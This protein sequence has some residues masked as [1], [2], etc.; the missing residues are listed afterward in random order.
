M[1]WLPAV[2]SEHTFLFASTRRTA[3]ARSQPPPLT[4]PPPPPLPFT[5]HV[6]PP[7]PHRSHH[8]PHTPPNPRPRTSATMSESKSFSADIAGH[9]TATAMSGKYNEN[10]C[11]AMWEE[12]SDEHDGKVTNFNE[13][14]EV[15]LGYTVELV[16]GGFLSRARALFRS[17]LPLRIHHTP[18]SI[19]LPSPPL[20]P[21]PLSVP[22][23][24][25][26]LSPLPSLPPLW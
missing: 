9:G 10:T 14:V 2:S 16:R 12:L 25:S 23:L 21:S 7:L 24:R 18:P 22:S 1:C 19:S 17:T 13:L 3:H 4:Y 20:P 6:L 15:R 11:V 8:P 5:P 26:S